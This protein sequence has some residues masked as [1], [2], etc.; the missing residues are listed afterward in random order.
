[1]VYNIGAVGRATEVGRCGA[2]MAQDIWNIPSGRSRRWVRRKDA[3]PRTPTWARFTIGILLAAVC[4]TL[5]WS[6]VARFLNSAHRS[7]PSE[8]SA[9]VAAGQ[10]VAI[11][12]QRD[13]ASSLET[14]VHEAE[15]GNITQAEVAIDRADAIVTAAKFRSETAALD[16]F[17][18]NLSR[19]DRAV[20]AAPDNARL[21]EHAT[22]MR[23]ELAQLRSALDAPPAQALTPR[24]VSI[25]LPRSIARDS[26]LDPTALGGNI[27]DATMMPTSAEILEPPYS[28]LLVDNVRVEHLNLQGATQTLDGIHWR[29]VTFSGTRLRYQGGEA[30]LQNVHF[31]RCT[32][33]FANVERSARLANA[34][35]LG[36]SSFVIE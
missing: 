25:S 21:A 13:T 6:E 34:I 26:T 32:F 1:M 33:G 15:A 36:Q 16:F 7:A 35:A 27:L 2:N 29:D 23:I 12:W 20:S 5:L 24:P 3:G 17:E 19:L 18:M 30:D 22:L 9:T 11:A 8:N 28:R 31:V 10:P 14:A 4:G